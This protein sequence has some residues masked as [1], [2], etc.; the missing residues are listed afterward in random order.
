MDEQLRFNLRRGGV[1]RP[2]S[3][4]TLLPPQGTLNLGPP[5]GSPILPVTPNASP[6]QMSLNFAAQPAP[7][8]APAPAQG[9]LNFGRPLPPPTPAV[10]PGTQGVLNFNVPAPAPVPTQAQGSFNFARLLPPQPSVVPP[11]AQGSLNFNAP[12]PPPP[13]PPP[14]QGSLNFGPP[15]PMPARIAAPTSP[16]IPTPPAATGPGLMN[17]AGKALP[18]LAIGAGAINTADQVRQR[19]SSGESARSAINNT[20]QSNILNSVGMGRDSTGIP[21]YDKAINKL[22]PPPA[23]NGNAPGIVE[24]ARKFIPGTYATPEKPTAPPLPTTP[25]SRPGVEPLS[26][27][28]TITRGVTPAGSGMER[29]V[30]TSPEGAAMGAVPVGRGQGGFVG[31][32]ADEEAGRNLQ[33][34]FQQDAAASQMAQS[35]DRST[36]ALRDLRAERMGIPRSQLDVAEGRLKSQ[37][38]QTAAVGQT[39]QGFGDDVLDRDRFLRQFQPK[40]GS[41]G[42]AKRRA[43]ANT[44]AAQQ[45]WDQNQQAM[46]R[47]VAQ[48]PTV[49]PLD[50]KRLLVDMQNNAARQGVD[51]ERLLIDKGN[52]QNQTAKTSLEEKKQDLEAKSAFTENFSIG[53]EGAPDTELATGAWEISKATGIPAEIV[54]GYIQRSDIDWKNGPPENMTKY[55]ENITAQITR[56]YKGK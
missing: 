22:Q 4:P 16:A 36:N 49:N 3:P 35:F 30:Y 21:E 25:E 53:K 43:Q 5:A 19:V 34:R 52:L 1:P 24:I 39:G 7:A 10:Q 12:L 44:I 14:A 32:T 8:P 20:I 50:E 54:Q 45:M 18:G 9:S 41:L 46:Q 38:P 37:E 15:R 31:A 28:S 47:P 13:A 48:A 55:F 6:A 23:P 40:E 17:L 26:I 29:R 56:D 42:G 27:N 51:R 33:S 11:S 2:P